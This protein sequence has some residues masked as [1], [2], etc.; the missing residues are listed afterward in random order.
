MACAQVKRT[1]LTDKLARAVLAQLEALIYW[2]ERNL[3]AWIGRYSRRNIIYDI[4]VY[5][6]LH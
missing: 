2:W 5:K 6:S 1:Y 3:W 4:Y